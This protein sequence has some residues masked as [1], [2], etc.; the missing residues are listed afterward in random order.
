M[1]LCPKCEK[2]SDFSNWMYCY[3]EEREDVDL[4]RTELRCPYCKYV[5]GIY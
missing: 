5:K 4:D 1:V 3:L 2:E